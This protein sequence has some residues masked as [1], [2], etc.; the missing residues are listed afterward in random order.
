MLISPLLPSFGIDDVVRRSA[1]GLVSGSVK[2]LPGHRLTG[3]E[4]A[5]DVVVLASNVQVAQLLNGLTAEVI[6]YHMHLAPSKCKVLMQDWR[7]LMPAS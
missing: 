3:L 6:R 2:L 1:E 4:Y 5:D 7:K